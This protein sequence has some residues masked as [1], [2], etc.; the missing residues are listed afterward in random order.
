MIIS[1][2]HKYIFIKSEKTAGTSI[3]A[4]L[5]KHCGGEDMVT[6]L[7]DF[8]FNRNEKGEWIH[9]AM[10]AEGFYQHDPAAEV[11][12]K[13]P[14]E[15]WDG[16]FKFSITR[17]PWDR[18]VS[19]YSWEARNKPELKPHRRLRHKLGMP[20]DEFR[21]T[22]RLFREFVK[23]DWEN[24]D[25]FYVMD[26]AL[27]VDF[28]IRYERLQQDLDEVCRRV[29]LPQLELPRLKAGLRQAGHHL[30]E[31]YDEASR[32]IVADRHRND[33]R[34]FGYEFELP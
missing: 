3:E 32:E 16:Y 22:V 9:S 10:N 19:L 33:L 29:G 13:V 24:N 7:G 34:L 17:N 30:S 25:R 18:V 4:A 15:I 14:P 26:G 28:V 11:K 21:E 6:P 23:G 5:S 20:F 1:H 8:W 12:R 2:T 31:Y 27:C